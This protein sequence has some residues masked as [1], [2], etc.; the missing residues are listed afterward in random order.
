MQGELSISI[1]TV[2]GFGLTLARLLGLFIFLPW[3]GGQAGPSMA[4]VAFALAC[5]MAL[6]AKWPVVNGIPGV[7]TLIALLA[8]E[9]AIGLFAGVAT[10]W[11]SEI[12]TM[13]A[14]ALSV[15]AGYSF[16]STFD[17]NTQA[18]SGILQI[19][20]QLTAGLLFFTTGLDRELI[21]IF[22]ASL[23]TCPPGTFVLDPSLVHVLVRL[24]TEV[25]ALALRIA[26]PVIGLLF[27]VDLAMGVVSR[28]NA[29]MQMISLSFPVKMLVA[30]IMLASLLTAFPVLYKQ[31]SAHVVQAIRDH[32]RAAH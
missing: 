11:M 13:G 8:G 16:A 31:E 7:A 20:A 24:G 17:P 18:D 15:Q 25:F 21:R 23:E 29:Q 3:P 32:V 27:L 9:A 19:F 5:T 26:L 28:V 6:Q 10:A 30:L 12:F 1:S 22:A 14:Q 2:L 4:R